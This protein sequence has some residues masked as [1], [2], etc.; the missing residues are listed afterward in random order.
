MSENLN[1]PIYV[2][3]VRGLLDI[4]LPNSAFSSVGYAFLVSVQVTL[5]R[6]V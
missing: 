5:E 6:E 2:T 3:I 1:T 4:P